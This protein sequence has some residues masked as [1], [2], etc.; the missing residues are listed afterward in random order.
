MDCSLPGSSVH[1]DSLGKNTGVG[2]H[3]LLQGIFPIQGLNPGL[4]QNRQILYCLRHQGKP[5]LSSASSLLPWAKNVIH[6]K[7]T[8]QRAQHPEGLLSRHPRLDNKPLL[9]AALT[10][11]LAPS[12]GKSWLLSVSSLKPGDTG[13]APKTSSGP[14]FWETTSTA[15]LHPGVHCLFSFQPKAGDMPLV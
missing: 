8:L 10:S 7:S 15:A 12:L 1:G 3:A 5:F 11:D 13:L 4:P 2:C 14:H 6:M 9:V